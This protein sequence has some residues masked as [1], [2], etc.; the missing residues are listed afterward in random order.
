MHSNIISPILAAVLALG[1]A[2]C[3]TTPGDRAL[4]GGMLGAGTGALI[5]SIA[6]SAADG[7]LFGGLG[8]LALGA[9]TSSDTVNLGEPIWNHHASYSSRHRASR[10]ARNDE[11]CTT[12]ET[13]NARITTCPKR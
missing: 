11:H 12:R 6:G 9:L 4:S 10:T 13:A 2:G 1:L 8:G 5:G 3:G 7:A